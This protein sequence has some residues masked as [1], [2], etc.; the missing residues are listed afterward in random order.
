MYLSS[1]DEFANVITHGMGVLFSL[2]AAAYFWYRTAGSEVGFRVVCICFSLSMSA[3]YLFSTLSHAVK[4]P[5]KRKR[6]RAWDQGLIYCLITGTYGP[7]IWNATQGS[8]RLAMLV[9]VWGA[10]LAGF[11]SKVFASYRINSV[12]TA[13][14]LALGWLPAIPLINNTPWV[15]FLWMFL[16]GVSYSTGVV[17]LMQSSRI[18]YSHAAWHLMVVL[19]SLLH[20]VAVAKLIDLR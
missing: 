5:A 20:C 10:A 15:C 9:A 11:Y 3:V 6:L 19:G 18:K 13:S 2:A 7:F 14:Y 8:F 1:E 12:S 4:E 16:G 17:F